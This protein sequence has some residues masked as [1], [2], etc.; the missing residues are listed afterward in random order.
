MAFGKQTRKIPN[1]TKSLCKMLQVYDPCF[2]GIR[3]YL[4]IKE[5][6]SV[7]EIRGIHFD[8]IHYVNLILF[9]KLRPKF[10]LKQKDIVLTFDYGYHPYMR[11]LYKEKYGT[12]LLNL[13]NLLN[14]LNNRNW[15]DFRLKVLDTTVIQ[16]RNQTVKAGFK[17]SA[18]IFPMPAMSRRMIRQD[19]DS[20]HLDYYFPW[21]TITFTGKI[22][23]TKKSFGSR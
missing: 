8:Y 21:L 11:K 12:D 2:T 15:L 22:P 13:L 9:K 1:T 23:L 3:Q 6:E 14:V 16:L 17:A 19:W 18:A 10:H 5:L 4:L 20:W 7:K